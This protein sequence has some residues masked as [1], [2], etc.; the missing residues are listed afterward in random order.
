MRSR[1]RA[2]CDTHSCS[3][4]AHRHEDGV[5]LAA[6]TFVYR[7]RIGERKLRR[8]RVVM[9]DAV[10][11][12]STVDLPCLQR[13]PDCQHSNTVRLLSANMQHTDI[14]VADV[15]MVCFPVPTSV[16][17]TLTVRRVS[18]FNEPHPDRKIKRVNKHRAIPI[19]LTFL[20]SNVLSSCFFAAELIQSMKKAL[21]PPFASGG[22]T[23]RLRTYS[24][25]E[26]AVPA[27]RKA[28][29]PG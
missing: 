10:F 26:S 5:V 8:G 20:S 6:L 29:A 17:T 24:L 11:P 25:Q 12:L 9:T 13:T 2:G 18:S 1:C 4:H 3:R 27:A 16:I 7:Q 23:H 28:A 22:T 15:V 21:L 14:A 19:P